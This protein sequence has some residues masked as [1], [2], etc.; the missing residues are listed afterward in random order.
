MAASSKSIKRVELAVVGGGVAGTSL[1]IACAQTGIDVALIDRIDPQAMLQAGFD[2]RTTA[3]SFG[4]RRVMAGIGVWDDLA[5]AAQPILEIRV[6]D[7][8]SP[9]FLHYDHQALGD[10]PLGFIVEN[11]H[12][13]H[14]LLARAQSLDNL[15]IVAPAAVAR[16]EDIGAA[17]LIELADG[18]NLQAQLVAACDGR[19]S[20]LRQAA[21]IETLSW[22]YRQTALVAVIAHERPHGGV[23]VEHFRPAGPFAILPMTGNRSSIVWT[24]ESAL[25]PKL[26]KLDRKKFHAELTR[27]FGDFLGEIE[28]VAGSV[29]SYPLSF[30]HAKRYSAPRLALVGDAAHA[31][32]PI[33]GQGLNLGMRDVASLAEIAVDARRLGLD[34]GGGDLLARYERWR[35]FD[36]VALAAITDG[37]NR[38]FSNRLPPVALLRD[39]GLAAVNA[40]PPLKR[41][42]MRH[43]MG[44]V[45]DLPRLVKGEAL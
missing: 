5:G 20:A 11:A 33:A 21:G 42:L 41:Y 36:S 38:L 4:T 12:L 6:A 19:H 26:L 37:L 27:R 39:V 2:S 32:H 29:A 16:V 14:A 35:R 17:A 8:A 22:S 15:A 31:I 45:G 7:G 34:I 40:A 9:F 28:V 18:T 3:L 13:R 23:A 25:A 1:A 10:D 24:E 30:S 44:I 43:A